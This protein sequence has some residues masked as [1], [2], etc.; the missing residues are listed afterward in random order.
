M[1][2]TVN[3]M[4]H[5]WTEQEFQEWARNE[6]TAGIGDEKMVE[7]LK[8]ELQLDAE[9]DVDGVKMAVL[10]KEAETDDTSPAE[11]EVPGASEDEP[12]TESND[13]DEQGK[14]NDRPAKVPDTDEVVD[15]KVMADAEPSVDMQVEGEGDHVRRLEAEETDPIGLHKKATGLTDNP[16]LVNH[17][18]EDGKYHHGDQGE[19][20]EALAKFPTDTVTQQ[21]V[22]NNLMVYRNLMMPGRTHHEE[23][24]VAAQLK[25]WATIKMIL[26]QEGGNFTRT[27]GSLLAF[28]NEYR[29]SLFSE[30]YSRRYFPEMQATQRLSRKEAENFHAMLHVITTTCDPATRSKATRQVDL[31]AACSGFN[32]TD[33]HQRLIEFYSA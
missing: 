12:S 27:W 7:Y 2:R 31:D 24:G 6:V 1:S 16:K 29:D 13:T 26:R 25:L 23:E 10:G 5:N 15:R 20:S 28:A 22:K 17:I 19:P 14:E 9:V 32:D 30:K 3:K 11:G 21:T 18:G 33:M 8:E 4:P